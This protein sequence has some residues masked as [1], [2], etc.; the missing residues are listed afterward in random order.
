MDQIKLSDI[1]IYDIGNEIQ[2]V[3]TIWGGKGLTFITPGP[4]S[5]EDFKDIKLMKLTFSEWETL[6]RQ[7]DLVETEMFAKD[8]TGKL[9]KTL[10]RKTQRQIDAALQWLIFQKDNYSCRY[11][12]RTGIPL[13]VD[14]IDLWED[15]GATI[16]DNL[17]SACRKCNKDR[18]RMK[19]ED[20]IVSDTYLKKSV[21][22]S[23]AVIIANAKVLDTLED[24]KS[25][26]VQHI[27]SR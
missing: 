24:L 23:S 1:N 19:Y 22:L 21:N 13:T 7:A 8:P 26:R 10:F 17:I 9:V 2:I 15:G 14:H 4:N 27:R 16:E 3:G 18:G 5:V 11:C 20:W 25:K 6:L 12:G